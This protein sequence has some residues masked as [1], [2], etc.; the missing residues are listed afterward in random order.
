MVAK[1]TGRGRR[2]TYAK[3]FDPDMALGWLEQA[4][5]GKAAPAFDYDQALPRESSRTYRPPRH[6]Q[7]A[8]DVC[9]SECPVRAECLDFA[10]RIEVPRG[11]SGVYGGLTPNER[12]E[13]YDQQRGRIA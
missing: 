11:R 4:A 3:V 1:N 13:L 12:D 8:Q 5:C 9:R 10:L 6:V 2:N 7:D